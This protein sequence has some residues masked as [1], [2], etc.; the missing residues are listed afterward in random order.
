MSLALSFDYLRVEDRSQVRKITIYNP[1]KLNAL[2][3][4]MLRELS[5]AIDT[6]Y[7][8]KSLRGAVITGEGEKAFA[9]GADIQEFVGLSAKEAAQLSEEGQALFLRISSCP[10]PIVAA[11]RGF[12]LGGGCEL[13]MACHLR[14]A[15]SSARFAQPEV[16][17]GLVPGYGGTQRLVELIGKTRAMEWILT[18][19][20]YTAEEAL[21]AGLLNA[22]VEKEEELLPRA[23]ELLELTKGGSPEAIAAAIKCVNQ[24]IPPQEFKAEVKAFANCATTENFREGTAAFLEKRKPNFSD[25]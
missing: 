22:V 9:A 23:Y 4:A 7:K 5:K 10:R 3:R 25:K 14:I 17:L 8:E 16:K 19:K 18:G 20:I 15:S 12:A 6:L 11:V 13:A 21:K 1:K 24:A 2:H